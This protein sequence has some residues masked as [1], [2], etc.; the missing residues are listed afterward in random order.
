MAAGPTTSAQQKQLSP[1][2]RLSGAPE[3]E[4]VAAGAFLPVECVLSE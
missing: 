4:W 1:R 2:S 3:S